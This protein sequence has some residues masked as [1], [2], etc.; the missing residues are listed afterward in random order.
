MLNYI[1]TP[2]IPPQ[3]DREK[4]DFKAI[5]DIKG[6]SLARV[7]GSVKMSSYWKK[8]DGLINDFVPNEVTINLHV[9]RSFM[10]SR[11]GC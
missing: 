2:S 5:L 9:F 1:N 3:D 4:I 11:I 8:F 6:N 7:S 10:E